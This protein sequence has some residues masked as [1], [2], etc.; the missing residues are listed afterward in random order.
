M[1]KE[2]KDFDFLQEERGI[3]PR[4]IAS[5]YRVTLVYVGVK[6]A[7]YKI[8]KTSKEFKLI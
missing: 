8:V 6:E 1:K 4:L 5:T 7:F 3:K 2:N